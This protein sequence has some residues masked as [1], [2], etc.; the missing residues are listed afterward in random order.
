MPDA[1]T[2]PPKRPAVAERETQ[3]T[4]LTRNTVWQSIPRLLGYVLSFASAPVIVAGLGLREFGIWALTGALAQYASLID[5]GAGISLARY[6]AAHQDD[7]TR[8]G[9]YMAI[10]W[11]A[12]AFVALVLTI[13]ALAIA[14]PLS[15]L[16][17]GISP[18]HMRVVL[19]ASVVL[20]C[21]S[22]LISVI[23]AFPVGNRRMV[24][25]NIAISIGAVVNFIASVLS[26]ALGAKLP[27]YALANAGAAVISVA[28]VA[29]LVVR[30]EGPLPFARPSLAQAR[31]FLAYSTKNQIVRLMDLVNYQTDKIVIAF[32]VGPAAAGAY[33]LANRVSIAVRQVGV[34][35]TSAIDIELTSVL[36]KGGLRAV[37]ARYRRYTEIAAII[38]FPAVLL[39]MATAPL[40][41]RAWLHHVPPNSE[42]VLVALCGAYLIA[43]S[44]GVGYGVAI[45]AG[46]P[47]IVAKT[48]VGTAVANIV[49]T[50]ALAPIFGI[51]GVLSGTVVALTV[52]ALAQ[53]AYVHRHYRLSPRA[54]LDAVGPPLRAY[55][56]LAIPVAVVSYSHL[57]ESRAASIVGLLLVAGY[58]IIACLWWAWRT[59]RLPSAV[60]NRLPRIG[61][62]APSR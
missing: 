52:G 7:E 29:G 37:K 28:V 5:L 2:A 62:L 35:A 47:G 12:V 61:R 40:L 48:S 55:V 17:K 1:L 46:E 57:L 41:L 38:G 53:V 60:A 42:L 19:L 3:P 44:T 32:T 31:V 16:V 43:V 8:C 45:A 36:R 9:Q 26:I 18:A 23:S 20:I 50:A 6:I 49:L 14:S 4:S 51:W 33:E 24:A 59:G 30:A 21:S 58:Y 34:Y 39:A 54:Y 11:L 27:G 10:G 25:P 56:L 22:M 15:H 13:I